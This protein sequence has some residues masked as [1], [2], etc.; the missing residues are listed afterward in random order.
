MINHF[1]FISMK[2]AEFYKFDNTFNNFNLKF[3]SYDVIC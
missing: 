3:I 2:S 1:L